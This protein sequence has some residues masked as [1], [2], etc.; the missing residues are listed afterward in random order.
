MS[1]LEDFLGSGKK[2]EPRADLEKIERKYQ[3]QSCNKFAEFANIERDTMT[4]YWNCEDGHE[5]KVT[6]NV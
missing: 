3:C 1:R 6:L 2:P 4:I 5:S